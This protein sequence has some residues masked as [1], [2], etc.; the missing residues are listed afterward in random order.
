LVIQNGIMVSCDKQP[1]ADS[2]LKCLRREWRVSPASEE[3]PIYDPR[4][5]GV[6]ARLRLFADLT[7]PL[8]TAVNVGG[9]GGSGR[10]AEALLQSACKAF[11]KGVKPE[12]D[13]AECTVQ[14]AQRTD[15]VLYPLGWYLSQTARNAL[16][17][18]ASCEV[19]VSVLREPR[20]GV[21]VQDCDCVGR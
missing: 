9:T 16:D 18:K 17:R 12:P 2:K 11:Q 3:Q 5:P 19:R 15:G 14:I 20:C 10:R 6:T 4:M 1:D 21:G 8:V 13:Q 7:G